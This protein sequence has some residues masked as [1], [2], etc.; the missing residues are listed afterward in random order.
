MKIDKSKP[1]HWLCLALFGMNVLAS[2]FARPFVGK[3]KGKKRVVLYGHRLNGNLLALRQRWLAGNRQFF[4]MVFLTMDK[5]Y[6]RQLQSAGIEAVLATR[7]GTIGLLAGADA[8]V[9]DHGLHVMSPLLC[10]GGLKF[11]DVWHGIPFKGFDSRDFHIQHRYDRVWVASELCKELYVKNFGFDEARVV[12][13][14]YARTDRLLEP[15]HDELALR[16]SYGIPMGK[17]TILF[18]PTWKQDDRGRSI[19]P[20]GCDEQEFLRTLA[21]FAHSHDAVILLRK[22]LNSQPTRETGHGNVIS[23]PAA[24]HPDTESILLASDVLVCDWSSIAFD[25]LLLDRPTI[26]LDVAPPFRKGYSLGPQY[27][28]GPVARSM[29]EMLH[30]LE[31]C[32]VDSGAYWRAHAGGHYKAKAAVY[33]EAADRRSANRCLGDLRNTLYSG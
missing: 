2:I 22:H 6:Y 8:I 28:F 10:V 5:A 27:R 12:V 25:F 17:K 15:V 1:G 29:A 9:S 18:A 13:T 11:F 31:S 21:K 16:S 4:E 14:G 30:Q 23:L 26:F 32:V 20:F 24:T 3:A 19:Y 7:L 33:G